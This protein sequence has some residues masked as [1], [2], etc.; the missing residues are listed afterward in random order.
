MYIYWKVT[1]IAKHKLLIAHMFYNIRYRCLCARGLYKTNNWKPRETRFNLATNESRSIKIPIPLRVHSQWTDTR[2][3][4][5]KTRV[6]LSSIAWYKLH[7][8]AWHVA[9][10]LA[11][12]CTSCAVTSV[13]MSSLRQMRSKN[14]HSLSSLLS[15]FMAAGYNEHSHFL[16]LIHNLIWLVVV[17]LHWPHWAT[18]LDFLI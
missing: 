9:K 2:K 4:S 11:W 17:R 18:L 5:E 14:E 15:F 13:H 16:S 8:R 6:T 12:R 1:I 7:L 10:Q 3:K